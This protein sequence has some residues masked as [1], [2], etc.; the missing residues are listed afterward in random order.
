MGKI[1]TAALFL[2]GLL[3]GSPVQARNFGEALELRVS[4]AALP[5]HARQ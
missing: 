4:R 5:T 1:V 3:F 2:V